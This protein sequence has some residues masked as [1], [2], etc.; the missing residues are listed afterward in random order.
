M[1]V[2]MILCERMD[3]NEAVVICGAERFSDYGGY[4]SSFHWRPMGK[5]DSFPRFFFSH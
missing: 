1:I 5:V 2:S 4:G 3:H